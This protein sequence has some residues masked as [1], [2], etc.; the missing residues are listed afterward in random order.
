[1]RFF[2]NKT[3]H[4]RKRYAFEELTAETSRGAPAYG[5]YPVID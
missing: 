5:R 2:L 4:A 1:M 3:T